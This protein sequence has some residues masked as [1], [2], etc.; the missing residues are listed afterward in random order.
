MLPYQAV[1]PGGVGRTKRVMALV[2]HVQSCQG[3]RSDIRGPAVA[4]LDQEGRE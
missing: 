2:G 4:E 3:G 1:H